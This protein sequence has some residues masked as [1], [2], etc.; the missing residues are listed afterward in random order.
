MAQIEISDKAAAELQQLA[1][2]DNR[3]LKFV[4]EEAIDSYLSFRLHEPPLTEDQIEHI[5]R[6]LAQ[7]QRG[8]LIPQEEVEA[9]FDDWEREIAAR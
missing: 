3:P 2:Q 5:K 1:L 8:E 6:S 9:F 4:A 7:A